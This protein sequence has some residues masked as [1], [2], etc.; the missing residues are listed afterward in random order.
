MKKLILI[1]LVSWP[2]LAFCQIDFF[3]CSKQN[4]GL[5]KLFKGDTI[6]S[7][8]VHDCWGPATDV[9]SSSFLLPS[10][11]PP[12]TGIYE[13]DEEEFEAMEKLEAW[14]CRYAAGNLG[15]GD[16][17]SAWVEGVKGHGIGE[18]VLV[19]C[20]DFKNDVRIWSGYGKSERLYYANSRP[21]KIRL[22][23]VRGQ[24]PVHTQYGIV[25][26]KLVVIAENEAELIDTNFY[27]SIEV[28]EFKVDSFYSPMFEEVM[29]YGYFLG[30]EILDVYPGSRWD[31]TCISEITS[32]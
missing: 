18:V 12:P 28:P 17:G 5:K 16:P 29:P 24:E 15:D 20:V 9:L 11:N 7:L 23:I 4:E 27:Q 30:L 25:W 31:D 32:K 3:I 14:S 2:V 10:G 21:K 26:E 6:K 22:C 1:C 8:Y 13:T 19:P